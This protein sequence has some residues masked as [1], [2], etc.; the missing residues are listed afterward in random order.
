MA[1]TRGPLRA[2]TDRQQVFLSTHE[3]PHGWINET[4]ECGHI[5]IEMINPAE[6]SDSRHR[7]QTKR[8]RCEACR[9]AK[10]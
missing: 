4:L 2:V 1:S 7:H 8:R 6:D 3:H 5:H 9:V 10:K